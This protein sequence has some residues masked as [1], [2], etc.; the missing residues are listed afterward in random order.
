MTS[1]ALFFTLSA[2]GISETAYLVRQRIANKKPVCF[3]TKDCHKVLE[4]KY[5]K[6]FG[7]HNDLV[8]LLFY[9]IL[10]F[11]AS[12]LVIEMRPLFLW[13]LLAQVMILGGT[14]MS[15]FFIY[16]QSRVIRAWCFWCLMSATTIFLMAIILI[17]Q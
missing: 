7:I 14:I 13:H 11:L 6:L 10:A 8:G 17:I 4:S 1:H 16:L 9:V 3:L 15:I 5:K 2:I 12:F